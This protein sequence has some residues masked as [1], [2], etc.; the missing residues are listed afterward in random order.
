MTAADRLTDLAA[1]REAKR[2]AKQGLMGYLKYT[3]P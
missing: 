2:G 3:N 1:K